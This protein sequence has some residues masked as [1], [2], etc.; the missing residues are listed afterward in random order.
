[1]RAAVTSYPLECV[2]SGGPDDAT[3]AYVEAAGPCFDDLRVVT[4]QLAGLLLLQASGARSAGP[5]HPMRAVAEELL[6]TARDATLRLAPRSPRA[7]H[8]HEHLLATAARLTEALA[9]IRAALLDREG[10]TEPTRL[11]NAAWTELGSASR[12][13]PGFDLIDLTGACCA[14]HTPGPVKA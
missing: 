2:T 3:R 6:E 7:R 8:H 11:L 10:V 4:A 5:D 14:M 1:M 12:A 13:L 9:R